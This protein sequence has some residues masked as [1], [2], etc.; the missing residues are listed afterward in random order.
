[1]SCG[2]ANSSCPLCLIVKVKAA[3][4]KEEQ[5]KDV[6]TA[7]LEPTRKEPGCIAYQLYTNE[8]KDTFFFYELWETPQHLEA[9]TKTEHY[10]HLVKVRVNLV[11]EGGET[12][13]LHEIL[14]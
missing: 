9:H 5:L 14:V 6:L 1:M 13:R 11:A 2:N 3:A 12:S 8:K 7:M 4:G 10:L